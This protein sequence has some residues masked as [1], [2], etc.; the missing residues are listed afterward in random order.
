MKS[1]FL[2]DR[3]VVK[4]AGEDARNFLNGLVTT[5]LDRLKPGLGRFGALLTP[6]GKI[7]VDFLITEVPA[8]HGGGFLIDCPKALAEGLATKLKFYKLRAKATVENLSDDLGVL[9]AWDGALA[10]QPDL[11]FADPRH[12]GLGTRILIPEDLKQKLSDLIGAELVDAAAYEAHRI[13]LGVPRGGLDFM[14]SD[15]FP[16]ETNMD[17][18]AGVDFDKGCY[19]GQ[20]VVSRMQHRGTARTRSVKVLLDGPSPEIGAAILAGDKPVGTIGSSADG[21]GIALVRIDRVADA[22]DAGQPLTAGGLALTLAEPE[23]V[24]IPA[25]QPTA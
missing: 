12:D 24:R 3:G 21:K 20:E 19:V 15:A 17:R 11:A 23:V 13:A 8:G 6:Q 2:P 22:L 18:L 25:K 16:H 10:A 7:I 14:Y 9:A 5:D 1:A 4:V